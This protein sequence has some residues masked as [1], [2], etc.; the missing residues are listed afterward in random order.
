MKISFIR[1]IISILIVFILTQ[2]SHLFAQI[3]CPTFQKRN[4]G[5]GQDNQC[6]SAT[7][8]PANYTKTG[9]FQFSAGSTSFT[10][11]SILKN[12]VKY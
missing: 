5:N 10:I 3:T 8:M 2:S 11:D 4:N 7:G 9:E 1:S 12:G 6:G